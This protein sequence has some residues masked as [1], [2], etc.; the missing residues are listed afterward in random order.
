M[1]AVFSAAPTWRLLVV[2]LLLGAAALGAL[3]PSGTTVTCELGGEC[4]SEAGTLLEAEGWRPLL[5]VYGGL[6]ALALAAF[7]LRVRIVAMALVVACAILVVLGAASL[8]I[9]L[10]P[11][12]VAAVVAE[13]RQQVAEG[14]P[15]PA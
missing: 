7:V 15:H 8:G 14:P 4:V 1:K 3:V 5:A 11:A 12:L 9:T 13:V 10:V 6:I 2:V